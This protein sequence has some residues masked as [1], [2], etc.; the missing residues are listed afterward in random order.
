VGLPIIRCHL[1]GLRRLI[2][3]IHGDGPAYLVGFR[4]LDSVLADVACLLAVAFVHSSHLLLARLQVALMVL[5]HVGCAGLHSLHH[6]TI[7]IDIRLAKC[8]LCKK[9]E[10]LIGLQILLL[11]LRK[12]GGLFLVE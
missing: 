4:A 7:G 11:R 8:F 6:L 12:F 2:F 9:R 10:I 1:W 3:L 5:G